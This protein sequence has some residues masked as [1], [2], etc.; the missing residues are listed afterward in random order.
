MTEERKHTDKSP[1]REARAA[2]VTEHL[3]AARE[4]LLSA[5]PE[6]LPEQSLSLKPLF[7]GIGVIILGAAIWMLSSGGGA[8]VATQ[9]PE[10]APQAVVEQ[11]R[12]SLALEA[13]REARERVRAAEEAARQARERRA[14][15]E[16]EQAAQRAREEEQARREAQEQAAA[17]A[18][19]RE[20]AQREVLE[21]RQAQARREAEERAARAEKQRQA[22]LAAQ[23]EQEAEAARAA[24]VARQAEIQREAEAQAALEREA[25]EREAMAPVVEETP[26]VE[27]APVPVVEAA[28]A[29]V[30]PRDPVAALRQARPG[31]TRA[32]AAVE[33][34]DAEFSADPCKGPSARFL[35]TCR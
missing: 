18:A 24:E 28:P 3:R 29:Q 17:L 7:I 1:S 23:R 16:A 9:E 13:A 15:L 2:S 30:E 32:D 25:M 26:A 19:E 12:A 27:P 14:A 21:A 34:S 10:P 33:E 6:P 22:A 4:E 11:E 8:P 20:T 35:S 31:E 5:T